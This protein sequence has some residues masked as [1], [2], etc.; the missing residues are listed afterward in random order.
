MKHRSQVWLAIL[1][2]VLIGLPACS[3]DDS[4]S[5]NSN[6]AT[7]TPTSVPTTVSGVPIYTY[8][9]VNVYPH[10]SNAFTQGLDY[11]D[12][13][14]YEGT[15]RTGRSSLR[16]C[17]LATGNISQIY[18]VPV[19]YFGEGIVVVEDRII[20]LTWKSRIGF[21]YDKDSF[22]LQ[23]QFTYQTE[24]W[25]IT[26]DGER[27][28][29]SDGTATLYFWDPVTLEELGNITVKDGNTTV[30]RLNELE[31]VDGEIYAN[32][33]QTDTIARIDPLTGGVVGWVYLQG[34]LASEG[35]TQGVDVLNG[36]AYD[37]ENDRLF[38]TG[39]LWPRLF[40]IE[41]VRY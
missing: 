35:I 28:I 21:V 40:E 33:W 16:K 29:M 17:E 1:F 15:G 30:T 20:Q 3:G 23:K 6:Y 26:Y 22:E 12:G 32:I 11:E 41:L 18:N 39:K 7:S 36:I 4:G 9:V 37:E 14:L 19:P 13:I 24:G 34:L 2:L 38:V 31:Y 10:D 5:N 27:L 8:K 25:G